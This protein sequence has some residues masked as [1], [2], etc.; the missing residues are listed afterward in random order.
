MAPHLLTVN[1]SRDNWL[2]HVTLNPGRCYD[3]EARLV[4]IAQAHESVLQWGACH[5]E[6]TQQ[7]ISG[8]DSIHAAA[9]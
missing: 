4:S 5:S 6:E 9:R 7:Y 2:Q 1:K 3:Y 8:R